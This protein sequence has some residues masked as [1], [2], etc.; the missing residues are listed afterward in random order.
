MFHEPVGGPL[1]EDKS[2]DYKTR[3]GLWMFLFYSIIY[4]IFVAI[5]VFSPTTMEKTIGGLNLAILYGFGLIVLALIQAVI[6]NHMC[7]K[8]EKSMNSK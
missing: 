6:Y 1:E 4:G 5:N 7:L 2:E 8:K 3:V